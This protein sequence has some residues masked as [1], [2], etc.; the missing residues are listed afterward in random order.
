DSKPGLVD[1]FT[2]KPDSKEEVSLA[3]FIKV[4]PKVLLRT[5][6]NP[7]YFLVVMAQAN[8]SVMVCG[9][10]TFM[11]KF[12]ERQFTIT[13]SIA[14]LMIGSVNIPGAMIGIVLGGVIMKRF[15]LS[16]KQ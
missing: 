13:A 12:L 7:V 16:P 1:A 9:L 10:A 8:L 4:F 6:K 11:A 14:N 3:K 15:Q 2:N 5:L